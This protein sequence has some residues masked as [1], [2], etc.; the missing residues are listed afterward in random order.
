MISD[1]TQ[2]KLPPQSPDCLITL[3]TLLRRLTHYH[4]LHTPHSTVP[5]H[6]THSDASHCP[7]LHI[8]GVPPHSLSVSI[9]PTRFTL[10]CT[11][12]TLSHFLSLS[13]HTSLLHPARLHLTSMNLHTSRTLLSLFRLLRYS[14][15]HYFFTLFH[16]SHTLPRSFALYLTPSRYFTLCRALP[17]CFRLFHSPSHFLIFFHPRSYVS[18]STRRS[19]TLPHIHSRSLGLSHNKSHSHSNIPLHSCHRHHHHHHSQ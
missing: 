5:R 15:F 19:S 18:Q 2:A 4:S 12:K 6:I 3:Q 10:P 9:I 8:K 1:I 7:T 16:T 17:H 11:S 13:L 14:E